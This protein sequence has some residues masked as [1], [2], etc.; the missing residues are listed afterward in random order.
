MICRELSKKYSLTLVSLCESKKEM[1]LQCDDEVFDKIHRIY[2]PKWLSYFFTFSFFILGRSLQEGYYFSPVMH[3]LIKKINGKYDF[4][5]CHLLRTGAYAINSEVPK[6]VELT[7][8]ISMNY[9]RV[10]GYSLRDIIYRIEKKRA[11]CI[12][13]LFSDKFSFCSLISHKDK[14]FLVVN[15]ADENKLLV[16]NNGVDCQEFISNYNPDIRTI[17]FIGNMLTLQNLEAATWFASKVMPLLLKFGDYRFRIIG[18][19]GAYEKRM[20]KHYKNIELYSNVERVQDYL[21]EAWIGVCPIWTGAGVQNKVLEYMALGLPSIITP[22]ALEGLDVIVE[23]DVLI[24]TSEEIFVE[25]IL[26]LLDLEKCNLLSKNGRLYVENNHNW[27]LRLKPIVN[28]V[29]DLVQS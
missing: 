13:Q 14:D 18:K 24:A 25:K 8:A 19:M 27:N 15:G 4:I 2:H 22:I 16:A 5:L 9:S 11:I 28:K 3:K 12:E 6:A 10:T 1:L 26:S 23:Q 29:D 17:V 7:D 21:K 20:L